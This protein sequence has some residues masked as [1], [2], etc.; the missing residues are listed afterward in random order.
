MMKVF[1]EI[2]MRRV[3]T[4]IAVC[5]CLFANQQSS[6]AAMQKSANPK[7]QTK[8]VND[9]TSSAANEQKKGNDNQSTADTK[10]QAE[11]A[12]DAEYI[13]PMHPEVRSKTK[14]KCP[15]CAMTLVSINPAV[16]DNFG[17]KMEATPSAPKANEKVRLRFTIFNPQTGEQVKEF[18]PTHEKL[19]H[20]FLISQDLTQ[21]QHIHPLFNSDSTF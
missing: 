2:T 8:S 9:K 20:L 3:L 4:I 12:D 13:C 10:A 21:F 5:L 6:F 19:F 17:L 14:G 15:K 16:V 7:A 18:T 1:R 11:A